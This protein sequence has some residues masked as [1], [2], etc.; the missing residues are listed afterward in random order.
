MPSILHTTWN[1]LL[2]GPQEH[3]VSVQMGSKKNN[4][5]LYCTLCGSI[6]TFRYKSMPEW[7]ISGLMCGQCYNKKLFEHYIA[8]Y[9]KT[10]QKGSKD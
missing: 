9:R 3:T 2:F 1:N 6:L 5:S 7:N 4:P 8:P 10:S